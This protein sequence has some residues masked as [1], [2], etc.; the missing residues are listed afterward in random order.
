MDLAR[1]AQ[2]YSTPDS[3]VHEQINPCTDDQARCLLYRYS[4]LI[5]VCNVKC[6]VVTNIPFASFLNEQTEDSRIEPDDSFSSPILIQHAIAH[7]TE[8]VRYCLLH[9]LHGHNLPLENWMSA[10][11]RTT[12]ARSWREGPKLVSKF[13]E[14][15][16]IT[17]RVERLV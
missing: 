12:L 6:I 8:D 5:V 11:Q 13:I 4:Y 7:W 14:V 3:V 17:S 2:H 1:Y 16:R 9:L 10:Q 15:T